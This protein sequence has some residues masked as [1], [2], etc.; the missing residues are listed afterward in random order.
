MKDCNISLT[1]KKSNLCVAVDVLKTGD[2]LQVMEQVGPYVCCVKTHVDIIS[3]W[4]Q[5]R[6]FFLL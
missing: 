3:D 1:R 4:S 5:V 2:L 6:T